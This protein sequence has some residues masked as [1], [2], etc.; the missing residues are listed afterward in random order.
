MNS[1]LPLVVTD[2][3]GNRDLAETGTVCGTVVPFGDTAG[4]AGAM[5]ELMENDA[6]RQ[7]Y[8]DAALRKVAQRFDLNKLA[9]D[10]FETY[11]ETEKC[12]HD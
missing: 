7:S 2:V 12:E 8:S 6:L 5:A 1:A 4:F 11:Q 9:L 3:G 10:V